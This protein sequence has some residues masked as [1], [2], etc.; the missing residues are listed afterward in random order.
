MHTWNNQ[1]VL[2]SDVN[3]IY[4]RHKVALLECELQEAIRMVHQKE[5]QEHMS[6]NYIYVRPPDVDELEIR[7]IR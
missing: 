7:L 3:E 5:A 1:G 6:F 2:L 4:S